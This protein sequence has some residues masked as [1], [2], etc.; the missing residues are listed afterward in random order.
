MTQAQTLCVAVVQLN[1][2]EDVRENLIACREYIAE[3]AELGATLVALPENF[4]FLGSESAKRA[5]AETL[6]A[7]PGPI[8]SMLREAAVRH[9]IHLLAGGWPERS[10][11][12]SRPYNAATMFSPEGAVAAHYRKI[13]LFDVDAPDG[14][15]YRE[16]NGVTPGSELVTVD[17]GGFRVGLSICYDLRFPELYRKLVDAGA[18]IL[19]APAAFTAATG[20]AHWHLLCRARAVESQCF[21]VAPG[22]WGVHLNDRRTYGHSLVVDPWGDILVDA[23]EGPGVYVAT[24]SRLHLDTVRQKLPSLRHRRLR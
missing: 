3:A 13:H 5:I 8:T 23:P 10:A 20:E 12:P 14:K 22:Q 11:D 18:E 7:P 21:V 19:C 4:A 17:V 24:L 1:S 2:R 16:S 6:D 15:A 9:H